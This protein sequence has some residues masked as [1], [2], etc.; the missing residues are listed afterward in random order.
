MFDSSGD[1]GFLTSAAGVSL[2]DNRRKGRLFKITSGTN[3]YAAQEVVLSEIDGSYTDGAYTISASTK[4]LWEINGVASVAANTVVE[5]W[6][7]PFGSGFYFDAAASALNSQ[8]TDGTEIDATTTDLRFDKTTGLKV[9]QLAGV[10]TV[11]YTG[12][13]GG[14]VYRVLIDSYIATTTATV[15]GTV[16]VTGVTLTNRYRDVTISRTGCT[17]LGTPYCEVSS[18]ACSASETVA[19]WCSGG[20]CYTVYP[21]GTPPAGAVGPHATKTACEA[22]PCTSPPTVATVSTSC[23][24][25]SKFLKVTYSTGEVFLIE[26]GG[27]QWSGQ[28]GASFSCAGASLTLTCTAGA[29]SIGAVASYRGPT[30]SAATPSATSPF[31][32]MYTGPETP[33]PACTGTVT[34]TVA[35]P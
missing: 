11:T 5:G 7:N 27:S 10:S 15:S 2:D 34:F 26:N 1:I 19:Y 21:G 13:C 30:N 6:P 16:V 29:W 28:T 18:G 8:N 32:L 22:S 12:A 24:T 20:V 4:S 23:G 9:T 14:L 33:S 31:L 3:P 25:V 35:E 17:T